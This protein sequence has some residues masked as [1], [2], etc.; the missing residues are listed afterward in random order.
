[1]QWNCVLLQVKQC[2]FRRRQLLLHSS[3]MRVYSVL[4][5]RKEA[6]AFQIETN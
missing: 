6:L 5:G 1:M 3:D 2:L 4:F